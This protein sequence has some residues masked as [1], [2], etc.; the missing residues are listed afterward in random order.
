MS[1]PKKV[2]LQGMP[3]YDEQKT[4]SETLKAGHLIEISSGQWRKHAG[5]ALNAPPI[6]A[7]E[8]DELGTGMETTYASGDRVK[9]GRFKKGDKVSCRIASGQNI[10]DGDY[11][12]S[13]GNG[14]LKKV[15][16]DA[17]T[18]DTQRIS[19]VGQADGGSGGAVVV[20]TIIRMWIV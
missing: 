3:T 19:I 15:A 6:F 11:L 12:E 9:A 13:A 8:R 17:A 5:A 14:T 10:A 4:A 2:A 1:T 7:M 20:E 18:D 16:T